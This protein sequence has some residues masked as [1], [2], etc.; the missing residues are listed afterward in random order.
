MNDYL[1]EIGELV[2][3]TEEVSQVIKMGNKRIQS[4]AKKFDLITCHTARRSFATNQYL[5][6]VPAYEIMAITGHRTFIYQGNT[7]T[8]CQE[9]GWKMEK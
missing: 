5:D 9:I 4:K 2:E 6:G 3:F 7:E 1:K 8:V